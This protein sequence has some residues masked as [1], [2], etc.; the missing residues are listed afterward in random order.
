MKFLPELL[1][2]RRLILASALLLALAGLFAWNTM[3]REEDPQFPP[4]DAL[5]VIEFPGADA[6]TVE[7]LVVEPVEERLAEVAE[8]DNLWTTAR[9]GVMIMRVE[10]QELVSEGETDEVWDDVREALTKA[11]REFPTGVG[12]VDMNDDLV[13]QEAV[14]LAIKGSADPLVLADAVETV[15][16]ALL[17]IDS[18]K[19]VNEIADPGEQITIEYDDAVARRLGVDPRRLGAELGER[20]RIVPGGLI[21]LGPKTVSLRPQT[22]FHTVEE[23][24]RT[25]IVLPSGASIPLGELA[26]VRRGP[27][28]PARERMRFNGVPALGLGVVPKMNLDRIAFGEEV[29][30]VLAEVAPT[31]AP[32]EIEEVAFQPASVETRLDQLA[33]SLKLGIVIVT[34]V[35]FLAMGLRLGVLV[36]LV[37]PLVTF[38][39][40]ALFAT[41][42]GILHQISIAALVIALGMLVDNA[43]VMVENIQWRLDAGLALREASVESVRELA[44]PLGTA[45]GTTLAA[46]VPM[47][48]SKGNTADF[49]RD[50]PLLIMLTLTVSYVFAVTVTP[51]LAELF[52]KRQTTEKDSRSARLSRGIAALAVGRP[53]WILVGVVLLIGGTVFAARWVDREFFPAADREVVLIDLELPEGTHLD[54]TDATARRVETALLELPEVR[55]VA[56]FIGRGTPRFYYNLM[57]EPNS[58][59]LAVLVARVSALDE[60][61]GLMAW[62]RDFVHRELPEA[63]VVARRLEQGPPLDAPIEIRLYGDDLVDLEDAAERVLA[64]IRAIPGTRDERHDLGLGVPTVRVEVDDAAA[65][66]HGLARSDVALA[67]LGR[68]L[69]LE[70]GQ[71]RFSED[72]VPILVRSSAGEELPSADLATV[73]VATP[74]GAPVPLAQMAHLELEWRPAAIFHHERRRL[75]KVQAQLAE[76]ITAH[77]IAALLMPRLEALELP[78]GVRYEYGGE[79][80]ESGKA[81]AALL[82]TMPLGLLLLLFF[83]LLEFNSFRRVAIVL[84]TVPLAAT[85]VVPGLLLSNQPFGFMSMLGVISLVGI[86]VNN[87]IVL[88]DVI[89]SRREEGLSI[90]DALAEAVARRTRPI[91]LTMATTVAGL[92][93]LAFSPSTLW[94]P[95]AWAMISGLMASTVLT[96]LVVPALYRVL[97]RDPDKTSDNAPDEETSAGTSRGAIVAGGMVVML[98]GVAGDAA[99][100]L[101][102]T[103][104]EA[105]VRAVERPRARAADG[106]ARAAELRATAERRSAW[107]P[108]AGAQLD[109]TRR[110]R[111]FTFDTPIGEFTLGERTSRAATLE[112]RQPLFDPARRRHAV[113]A[114]EAA[115]E[116][117][118]AQATR[119]RQQLAGSAAEAFV[120]VLEIDDRL[121]VTAAFLE[122]LEARL[123]EVEARVEAGRLLEADALEIR[124][125]LE[126]AELDRR[127]MRSMR[128]VAVADLGRAVGHDGPVE[129]RLESPTDRETPIDLDAWTSDALAHRAD[130][131]ALEQ[132]MLALELQA[133]AVRA[134]R[135]PR[136]EAV[137]RYQATSGDPF[138]AE[139]LLD[140]SVVLAWRPFASGTRAPRAAALDAERDALA[141]DLTE[142]RRAVAL[143][144]QEAV[145]RLET[146]RLAVDVRRRGVELAEETLRVERERHRAGRAT[147]NDLLDAEA[148][149]RRERTA[150]ELA[151]LDVLLAWVAVD[152]ARG[153]L[154]NEAA[155]RA[156]E[157]ENLE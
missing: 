49:T 57:R 155:D 116:V 3:P 41:M 144:L 16:R 89:E 30:A 52:L 69:G 28:E 40:I 100:Q 19:R 66:R 27:A 84:V 106:R 54:V 42:G 111:D 87:A 119:L 58:P 83:L 157:S 62:A 112:A 15:K 92:L 81:N 51:V 137:A 59:H 123:L 17:G 88:L 6:E 38:I 2:R 60:V 34:V 107:W 64:E 43:I 110:D 80:E 126:S 128:R 63:E 35:L 7:R 99:A 44:L 72:P 73:D 24:A 103:L 104:E 146:A 139:E 131:A 105:M 1:K 22:E 98:F 39:S 97:F 114:A 141:A 25:P 75:V 130:I 55:S 101:S 45:T 23:I 140:G 148:R 132:R 10:L 149:L 143:E 21:H 154:G 47:L 74:G 48:A 31:I 79:L 151:R 121:A 135:L 115:V 82:R 96:L 65:G 68:T 138:R 125:E 20:S 32:L 50:I 93:P 95:L 147:T 90:S 5:I 56:A 14:V 4:R 26:D 152:L 86:V 94:P 77:D 156:P 122:S 53:L 9:A 29:R 61:E 36:A 91:L 46:F 113:P 11:E 120:R 71:Y 134:E 124:L 33:G 142:L 70:V 18:V 109:V 67:L 78:A 76:D 37:L 108:S 8:I 12:E 102:L 145:S 150:N 13:E 129:P 118:T 85:G 133:G 127:R 153:G 136:L 117:A